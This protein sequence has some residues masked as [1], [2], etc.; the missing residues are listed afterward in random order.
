MILKCN[1]DLADCPAEPSFQAVL[2]TACDR[3]RERQ[4]QY[5]IRRIREMEAELDGLAKTLDEFMT[6]SAEINLK[7]I[8]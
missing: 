7:S 4:V 8:S 1:Y 3:L 2:D 5:S 6:G